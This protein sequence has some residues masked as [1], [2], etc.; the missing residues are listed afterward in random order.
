M[1]S[2]PTGSTDVEGHPAA[3][4]P[5]P[6]FVDWIL[7]ALIALSGLGLVVG[8]TALVFGVD[9]AVLAEGVED[10]TITVTI[11]MTELTDAETLEV[12]DAI[13]S[14]MGPGLIL[15]GLAMTLFGIGYIIM[16]RRAH[17]RSQVGE[18][19]SSY[20]AFAVLG[21]VVTALLSFLPISPAIGGALA[22]Y[23]EEVN[24]IE[25]SAL[26]RSQGCYLCCQ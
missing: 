23:L 25:L 11:G 15:T 6:E 19:V 10:G 14:W 21:G 16:R 13:V 22:G 8:G 9:R 18:S 17:R 1:G 5:L 26:E 12:T 2:T 4:G 20:G 24:L 3:D 7:G